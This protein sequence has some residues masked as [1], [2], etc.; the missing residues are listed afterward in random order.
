MTVDNLTKRHMGLVFSGGGARG[1]FQ[2]GVWKALK[3]L[4]LD[5]QIRHVYG[6]SVGAVNGAA[7]V[8]GDFEL[9][10]EI[11]SNLNY[12]RVFQDRKLTHSKR[13]SRQYYY[14]LAKAIIRDKGLNVGPLKDMLRSE[15]CEEKIRSSPLQFGLVVYDV[16]RRRPK[17]L[18]K[19]KIPEG[20]L[21]EYIIASATFPLFQ[22]HRIADEVFIDGGIYDNRPID[23]VANEKEVDEVI[24]VDV[25]IARH[26]WP[27]KRLGRKVEVYYLRPSRLLGSPLAFRLDRIAKNMQLGYE[28]G[29]NQLS[30][31]AAIQ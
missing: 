18:T 27:R 11:W 23:F 31:L 2:I 20:Q 21:I 1:A 10:K 6:T 22:P 28:D 30:D 8:Q 15:L 16:S 19:D 25:T 26:F 4:S 29:M 12:E 3:Q 7:F 9:A 13:R 24:C 14:A 17:Y 5:N